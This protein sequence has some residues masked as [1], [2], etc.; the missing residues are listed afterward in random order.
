MQV[1]FGGWCVALIQRGLNTHGLV[2]QREKFFARVQSDIFEVDLG[3][4][5]HEPEPQRE[6]SVCM[7]GREVA[8]ASGR[9]DGPRR[10]GPASTVEVMQCRRGPCASSSMPARSGTYATCQN[11]R[12]TTCAVAI[13]VPATGARAREFWATADFMAVELRASSPAPGSRR[14]TTYCTP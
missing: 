13:P 2:S 1:K 12:N 14:A 6:N 10:V 8:V 7:C 3:R 4:H 9:A 5:Q 11:K